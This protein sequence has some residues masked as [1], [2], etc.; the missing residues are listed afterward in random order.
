[1]MLVN[2]PEMPVLNT[3][4]NKVATSAARIPYSNAV[5]PSSSRR[6]FLTDTF[7]TDP[8]WS[9]RLLTLP[10]IPDDAHSVTHR[11]GCPRASTKVA[12]ALNRVIEDS[13]PAPACGARVLEGGVS[14]IDLRESGGESDRLAGDGVDHVRT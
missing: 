12:T 7:M 2:T 6:N 3:V 14:A 9:T 13:A 5:M 11:P 1:M 10:T 8:S 4:T